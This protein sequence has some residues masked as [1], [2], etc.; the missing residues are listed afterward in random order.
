MHITVEAADPELSALLFTKRIAIEGVRSAE[1]EQAWT[2]RLSSICFFDESDLSLD[3]QEGLAAAYAESVAVSPPP[4][5]DRFSPDELT[6]FYEWMDEIEAAVD[7][8][9]GTPSAT[10]VEA[11]HRG[12]AH[13]VVIPVNEPV[14][15]KIGAHRLLV[16][17]AVWNDP[18]A[19]DAAVGSW[20]E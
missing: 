3:G 6:S 12:L 8:L 14:I 5:S 4:W 13:F 15:Q 9:A 16:S 17:Q 19:L 2:N 20:S 11:W 10:L 1:W 7:P 18:A